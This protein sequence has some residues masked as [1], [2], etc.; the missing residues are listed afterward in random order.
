MSK[1]VSVPVCV[2]CSISLLGS[3]PK[4]EHIYHVSLCTERNTAAMSGQ[5][6]QKRKR[7]LRATGW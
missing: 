5:L 6:H 4:E 3:F 2:S 7:R 1:Y